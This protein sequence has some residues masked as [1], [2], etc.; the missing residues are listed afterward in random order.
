[1]SLRLV[2]NDNKNINV[3][4]EEILDFKLIT[5]MLDINDTENNI[6]ELADDYEI[7]LDI[8]YNILSKILEFSNFELNNKETHIHTKSVFYNEYFTCEDDVLFGIMNCA[9]YLN[10]DYLLDKACDKLSDDIL[11]CDTVQDVKKKFKIT[12]EFTEEEEN[13][14]LEYA[15]M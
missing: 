11:K 15:K 14:I 5:N 3:S 13:E 8:S 4:L 7:P 1:M 9:D 6:Y 2:T 10:Y 12:R